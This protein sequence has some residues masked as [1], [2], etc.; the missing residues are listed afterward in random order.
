M[1]DVFNLVYLQ[2]G[3]LELSQLPKVCKGTYHI[4]VSQD[5]SKTNFTYKVFR[6]VHIL[7]RV[8]LVFVV[9]NFTFSNGLSAPHFQKLLMKMTA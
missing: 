5:T 3:Y 2:L 1:Y 7:N 9:Q 4:C 8:Y 6:L